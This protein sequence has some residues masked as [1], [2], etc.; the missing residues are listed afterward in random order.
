[1][2]ACRTPEGRAAWV[3]GF[4]VHKFGLARLQSSLQH[5]IKS[6]LYPKNHPSETKRGTLT[7]K[8]HKSHI[9]THL[10]ASEMQVSWIASSKFIKTHFMIR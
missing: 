7:P 1:M 8:G 3:N 4:R 5:A 9:G 2:F 10:I 6:A